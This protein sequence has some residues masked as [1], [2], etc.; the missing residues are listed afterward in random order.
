MKHKIT[1]TPLNC[2]WS[3][4]LNPLLKMEESEYISSSG[5]CIYCK[6]P[7]LSWFKMKST[8]G[9]TP[10]VE[11]VLFGVKVG[12]I[13]TV[14]FD[15]LLYSGAG[16][17][18]FSI[19]PIL[20]GNA[21]GAVKN[22]NFPTGVLKSHYKHFKISVPI[23]S[24]ATNQIGVL[25]NVRPAATSTNSEIIFKNIEIEVET[26]NEK[27]ALYN[28]IVKYDNKLD[29]LNCINLYSGT[30]VRTTYNT[31]LDLYTA[32]EISFPDDN[33][34]ASTGATANKF[35]GLCCEFT[36][37]NHPN[38]YVLYLEYINNDSNP[39][40]LT[41]NGYDSANTHNTHSVAELPITETWKKK[42]I[43][44]NGTN[45]KFEKT[46][47][48]IGKTSGASNFQIRNVRFSNPRFD[49]FTKKAPNQLEELF[50]NLGT[51]LR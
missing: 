8:P 19:L 42:I 37:N 17:L 33:T 26:T 41:V 2:S 3:L 28:N 34:M 38:P 24:I 14:D 46:F 5:R 49:D 30:N 27:F 7:D 21:L 15:A 23:E 40:A 18:L 45:L 44:V 11:P 13:I 32:S 43:Y 35:R 22:Y 1:I 25:L 16:E 51:K 29:Y 20:S 6:S 39:I 31:L 47:M 48:D 9:T 50:T 12:D 10:Y 4:G 36:A